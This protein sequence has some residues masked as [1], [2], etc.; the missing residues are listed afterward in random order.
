[1][2]LMSVMPMRGVTA[3][4]FTETPTPTG[5]IKKAS[6]PT[7]GII[8]QLSGLIKP[9]NLQFFKAKI[10]IFFDYKKILYKI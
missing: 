7:S 6:A 8:L 5:K 1:M 10:S 4:V 2:V 3:S 9:L